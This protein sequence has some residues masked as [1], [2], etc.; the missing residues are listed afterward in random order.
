MAL[1]LLRSGT[2]MIT[3]CTWQ[4][5]GFNNFAPNCVQFQVIFHDVISLPPASNSNS[6]QISHLYVF[7]A[8]TWAL[9]ARELF[10]STLILIMTHIL[11]GWKKKKKSSFESIKSFSE[12]R[13]KQSLMK[14]ICLPFFFC[15]ADK[16][17][18]E[19]MSKNLNMFFIKKKGESLLFSGLK[20]I[21]HIYCRNIKNQ[22]YVR[23]HN[24][25]LGSI[26]IWRS[27]Q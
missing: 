13:S 9:K 21:Q 16:K 4:R 7:I 15:S 19:K 18:K 26:N 27:F 12:L 22:Y 14:N 1:A 6:K 8:L 25:S 5:K 20:S 24:M 3:T 10:M 11:K 2:R 23:K 17:K